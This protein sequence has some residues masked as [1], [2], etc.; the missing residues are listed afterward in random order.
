MARASTS[1]RR[2]R[3]FV[4]RGGRRRQAATGAL[5]STVEDGVR[6]GRAHRT[7]AH[8]PQRRATTSDGHRPR[9]GDAAERAPP[10]LVDAEV[11][12]PDGSACHLI[13][14]RT[15]SRVTL[16]SDLQLAEVRPGAVVAGQLRWRNGESGAGEWHALSEERL[17]GPA[18]RGALR[19]ERGGPPRLLPQRR[20]PRAPPPAPMRRRRRDRQLLD[21]RALGQER[22]ANRLPPALTAD[23]QA[24]SVPPW[25][26]MCERRRHGARRGTRARRLPVPPETLAVRLRERV[27]W[28]GCCCPPFG[29]A[30]E[31][32][33]TPPACRS[34]RH[35]T[36]AEGRA[37]ISISGLGTGTPSAP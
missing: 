24:I 32:E 36:S 21:G 3:L 13:P 29:W 26:L 30:V 28:K 16:E 4:G 7:P 6:G 10:P 14:A 12:R 17:A 25:P 2:R 5:D 9:R 35:A 1:G 31:Q 23:A 15:R 19:S 33:R 8:A 27:V 34:P 22:G 20:A 18:D 11:A 37:A